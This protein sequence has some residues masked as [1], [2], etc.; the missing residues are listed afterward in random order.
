MA[1]FSDGELDVVP[2]T[3][4]EQRTR[5]GVAKAYAPGVDLGTEPGA[6]AA[7]QAARDSLCRPGGLADQVRASKVWTFGVGLARGSSEGLDFSLMR[8]VSVGSVPGGPGCGAILAPSPGE[9]VLASDIDDL[10]FA[11]DR[12]ASPQQPPIEQAGGVCQGVVCTEEAHTF[13]LDASI[14]A[15]HILGSSDVP[16][17]RAVLVSPLGEPVELTRG[18]TGAAVQQALGSAQI[19]W[20]WESESTVAVDL[21]SVAPDA[22]WSGP[23]SLVFVD[24]T[25]SSP[26]ATSRSNIR[27][28]GDIAPTWTSPDDQPLH[29]GEVVPGFRLGLANTAGVVIDPSTLLGT[30]AAS[31]A[32]LAS[33]GTATP[34]S[35]D[36][37]AADLAND[38]AL[39][40]TDA[41]PGDAVLRLQLQITT[42]SATSADGTVTPGTALA[43]QRVDLPITLLAPVDFPG[44]S[45]RLSFG[46]SEGPADLRAQLRVTGPGCVWIADAAPSLQ[47]FPEEVGSVSVGTPDATSPTTCLVV[48][49]GDQVDLPVTFTT[50]EAG[51]GSVNGTVSVSIAPIDETERATTVEIPFTADLRKPVQGTTWLAGFVLAL[52][53]G[54]GIPIGLLY[55]VKAVTA[56]IPPR[57]LSAALIPVT[58]SGGAVLRD[59]E[60]FALRDTDLVE[61]VRLSARGARSATAAGT[62]LRTRVGYSPFGPATVVVEAPGVGASSAFPAPFGSRHRARLPLAVHNTWAVLVDGAAADDAASLLLLVGA[63]ASASRREQLVADVRR[64]VPDLVRD[65][66]ALVGPS[67]GAPA[68]PAAPADQFSWSDDGGA[69]VGSPISPVAGG[70]GR[71]DAAARDPFDFSS[72]EDPAR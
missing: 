47:A 34:V 1:W 5:D 19:A 15:V 33:D 3:T 56:R 22:S 64:R 32:V 71:P 25:A 51:N 8:S 69:P 61:L 14:T 10:L 11:F 39:D 36:L 62:T 31:V 4:D 53:L 12:F 67:A 60:P 50:E 38:I 27:I 46:T 40:L 29:V 6:A 24:D 13:V 16:G 9:F 49:E 65:L 21:T 26:A 48:A 44:V 54:P 2:R 63:D 70:P 52:L 41:A 20:T 23:W 58:I 28:S 59:G 45:G 7:E 17:V 42:A 30:V 35:T 68:G 18:T 55:L 57:A 43:P 37:T 66:R 72:F